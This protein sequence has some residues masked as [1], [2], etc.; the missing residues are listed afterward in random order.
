MRTGIW[1]KTG[2]AGLLLALGLAGCGGGSG[3]EDT[4]ASPGVPPPTPTSKPAM[5]TGTITSV[6]TTTLAVNGIAFE[7]GT[8]LVSKGDHAAVLADLDVG[9][10]VT[11]TGRVDDR[12]GRGTAERIDYRADV[13]GPIS[14]LDAA[15]GTFIVLGQVVRIDATTSFA[16][17]AEVGTLQVNAVV[18]VCGFRNAAGEIV[19]TRIE[20]RGAGVV[21]FEVRG[22]VSNLDTAAR[23]FQLAMLVV[24]Y[25]RAMLEGFAS[26]E[27][28]AGDFVEVHASGIGAGGELLATRVEREEEPVAGGDVRIV[29]EGLITGI[30]SPFEIEID[31]RLVVIGPNTVIEFE[32]DVRIE[33][34]LDVR[35]E[36]EGTLDVQG[37]LIAIKLRLRSASD[38]RLA[39][40]IDA[41]DAAARELRVL[42]TIVRIS[43]FARLED[44]SAA[45]LRP[46]TLADLRPGDYVEMRGIELPV[47]QSAP[48]SAPH[49]L[50]LRLERRPPSDEVRVRG[51]V[52]SIERPRFLV[53][54]IA[55]ETTPATRFEATNA[56]AFFAGAL[57]RRVDARGTANGSVVT[58]REVEFE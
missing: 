34:G 39:A 38:A 58:V 29:V 53:L 42:G 35:I 11:V 45:Q 28:R 4:S 36:V 47:A 19:A 21:E 41:V 20:L 14:S 7:A 9:H 48:G 51:R 25:S 23:R 30:V 3:A 6:G 54:G 56:D 15:A 55:L 33:F 52:R 22:R 10:I 40:R 37:R 57:G 5:T 32:G 24:D 26:G 46:F 12:T 44:Q 1:G 31:G 17:G 18:E 43:Q 49:L 8:A 13:L 27:P 2:L 16:G 50:A